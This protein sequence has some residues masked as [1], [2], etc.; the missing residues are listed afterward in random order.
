MMSI[1]NPMFTNH[2]IKI[3]EE[4]YRVKTLEIGHNMQSALP[5]QFLMVW[6]PGVGERPMS[7]GNSNPLTISVA[8]VGKVSKEICALKVGDVISYR[9]P[10]GTPFWIP[11]KNSSENDSKAKQNILVIGGGYGIVPMYFLSKIAKENKINSTAVIGGRSDKDIIY[12]KQLFAVCKEV[13]VATDDGSR[14]KKGTVMAEADFLIKS[15]KFDCVYACGPERMMHTVA[16]LCKEH[17]VPCQ[18]SV[19]R[20]MKCGFGV[21]GSCDCSGKTACVNGPVMSGEDALNLPEFGKAHRDAAG[22]LES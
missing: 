7:I 16:H 21:C 3:I 4:N 1:K 10:F 6:V 12:E 17:G 13:F 15:K 8:D 2:V 9:G 19:E 5:G 18:V 20:Y 11:E 14:G 22:R